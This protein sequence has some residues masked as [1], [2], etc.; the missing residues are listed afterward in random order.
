MIV[1]SSLLLL[2][3]LRG[4]CVASALDGMVSTFLMVF[5]RFY[6]GTI[7]LVR[8]EDWDGWLRHNRRRCRQ[9]KAASFGEKGLPTANP[10]CAKLTWRNELLMRGDEVVPGESG[11]IDTRGGWSRA[12]VKGKIPP[13]AS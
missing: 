12:L 2:R 13:C 4:I 1:E 9:K 11:I 10:E 6:L 3:A 7:L 8:G 5:G